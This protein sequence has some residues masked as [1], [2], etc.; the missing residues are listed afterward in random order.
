MQE[1]CLTSAYELV[2]EMASETFYDVLNERE[3]LFENCLLFGNLF[4]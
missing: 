2:N 4:A 1:G 3:C